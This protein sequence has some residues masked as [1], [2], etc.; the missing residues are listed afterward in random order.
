MATYSN[1][2]AWRIPW[3]EELGKLQFMGLQRAGHDWLT[4]SLLMI[5]RWTSS[6]TPLENYIR[7]WA[8]PIDNRSFMS[9]DQIISKFWPI[10]HALPTVLLAQLL[11]RSTHCLVRRNGCFNFFPLSLTGWG[12]RCIWYLERRATRQSPRRFLHLLRNVNQQRVTFQHFNFLRRMV[13]SEDH[14]HWALCLHFP[15]MRGFQKFLLSEE[16][17]QVLY[18]KDFYFLPS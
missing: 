7:Q 12:G 4:L 9:L 8:G 13:G 10:A 15:C 14:V 3:T 5:L 17:Q 18:E 11:G 2:L 16:L 1:I 6:L